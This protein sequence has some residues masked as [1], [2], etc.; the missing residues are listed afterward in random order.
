MS[1]SLKRYERSPT[2]DDGG[3]IDPPVPSL[4]AAATAREEVTNNEKGAGK[5]NRRTLTMSTG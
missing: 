1:P 5:K 3:S 2:F 4:T